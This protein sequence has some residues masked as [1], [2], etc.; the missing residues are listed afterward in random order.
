MLYLNDVHYTFNFL[1]KEYL[2]I[3]DCCY[4]FEGIEVAHITNS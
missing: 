3:N 4:T 2:N 1:A